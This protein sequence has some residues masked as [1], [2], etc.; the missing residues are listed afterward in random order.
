MLVGYKPITCSEWWNI[1]YVCFGYAKSIVTPF[2]L[3]H[4]YT[5][6]RADRRSRGSPE[7]TPLKT[8]QFLLGCTNISCF[9]AFI[10]WRWLKGVITECWWEILF[11]RYTAHD[12]ALCCRTITWKSPEKVLEFCLY[13]IVRS[14]IPI[15]CWFLNTLMT[16][17][18]KWHKQIKYLK[19]FGS[20]STVPWNFG[21]FRLLDKVLM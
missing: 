18:L 3:F 14:M 1:I 19:Y 12:T 6:T 8:S 4:N 7:K 16:L 5:S 13:E 11:M 9:N 20:S 10:G 15:F 21:I 17:W 2:M